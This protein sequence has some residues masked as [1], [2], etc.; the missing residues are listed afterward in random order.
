MNI[1]KRFWILA[2]ILSLSAL[3]PRSIWANSKFLNVQGLL[4]NSS[5]SPLT[6]T[7][8]V[9]FRLYTSSTA[10]VGSAVWS[11]SDS[12]SL[13]T[14]IFNLTLG[15]TTALDPLSFSQLYYL[16]IQV[17]GD[18]NELSPRQALGASAYAQGSMGAFNIG[19]QAVIVGTMTVQ[20]N[21]F[22]VGGSVLN[23]NS[24]GNVGIGTANPATSL[25]VEANVTNFAAIINQNG[26]TYSSQ[27]GLQIQ[28][29]STGVPSLAVLNAGTTN[30]VVRGN[31]NV[32]I[33][34]TAPNSTLEVKGTA[35]LGSASAP[36]NINGANNIMIWGMGGNGMRLSS[37]TTAGS[38][39]DAE[40]YMSN[41]GLGIIP[42]SGVGGGIFINMYSGNVGIGTT[43]PAYLLDVNGPAHASSFPTSSDSRLKTS[44]APISGALSLVQKINGIHFNWNQTYVKEKFGDR[45]SDVKTSSF[46][47]WDSQFRVYTSTSSPLPAWLYQRQ[48]GVV[49][50]DVESVV[51]E[52]ITTWGPKKYRA[53]DYGRLTSVLVEAIKELKT[54]NDAQQ[55]QIDDLTARLK[56]LEKGSK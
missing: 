33:G 12:V 39:G 56:S 8:T 47:V 48:V 28:T 6:G 52:L 7:Q 38:L 18:S 37:A 53:M 54:K 3:A 20:G 24:S 46:T 25:D 42:W 10:S 43:G 32:G 19:G 41:T 29:N 31:G 5:G 26:G 23:V 14:G 36:D 35:I 50:Q 9:T 22:S 17:A 13:S 1:P 55:H 4:T 45:V 51:P 40:V 15:S 34:T 49:A 30:F 11:E 16:G 44:T 21:A 2:G 27:G